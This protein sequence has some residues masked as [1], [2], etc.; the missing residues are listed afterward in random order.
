MLLRMRL[1]RA[2]QRLS[3]R[4]WQVTPGAYFNGE[5]MACDQP[6]CWATSCHPLLPDWESPGSLNRWW[7]DRPHAV[8]LPTG[9]SFDAIEVPALLGTAARVPLGPVIV[10]PNRRWVFLVRTGSTLCP[11]LA[12]RT[13]VVLH[14]EHSWV[15]A[16]PSVLPEGPVRWQWTP[17][18]ARW[19]VPDAQVLQ[20]ALVGALVNLD[21]SFLDLP[22]AVRR[23]TSIVVSSTMETAL[24]RAS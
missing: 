19:N 11:E 1:R 20:K 12:H 2:A 5:R 10:L 7:S 21:A 24:R 23:R 18:Q 14:A 16:P 4:G 6:T 13:D 8:L 22:L 9:Q 17:A 15:P 3:S